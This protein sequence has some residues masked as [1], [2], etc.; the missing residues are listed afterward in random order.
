MGKVLLCLPSSDSAFVIC[1]KF[2][3]ELGHQVELFEYRALARG[4]T[5]RFSRFWQRILSIV[6]N[7]K[8]NVQISLG[9]YAQHVVSLSE[10]SSTCGI[11][12]TLRDGM[13]CTDVET[14]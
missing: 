14:V 2:I 7:P 5:S 1:Q 6:L 8:K 3:E 9:R 13:S 4:K 10:L 11:Y 12:R